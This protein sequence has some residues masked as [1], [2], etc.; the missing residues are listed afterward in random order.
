[1]ARISILIPD[2]ESTLTG[3][4]VHSLSADRSIDIHVL[5][6]DPDSAIQFSRFVKTFAVYDPKEVGELQPGPE[7]QGDT[8]TEELIRYHYYDA[9][10]SQHLIEAIRRRAK[11]V[12]ATLLFPVDEHIV[13][14]LSGHRD[15][16]RAFI[17]LA[18][19]PDQ[20]MFLTGIDKWKLAQFLKAHQVPHPTTV[21]YTAGMSN[22]ALQ[23]IRFPVII[24]PINLGNAQGIRS[25]E[26]ATELWEYLQHQKLTHE[27]IIQPLITGYDIDCSV[28]CRDGKIVA[29]TI[30][31]AIIHPKKKYRAAV[32]IEFLKNDRVLAVVDSMMK[33]LNWSGVAHIDLRYDQDD[34]QVKVIEINGRY[35]G[36][37]LGST[38]A[39]VNFPLLAVDVATGRSFGMPEFKMARYFMGKAPIPN[40]AKSLLTSRPV[41]LRETSLF[42]TLRDPMPVVREVLRKFRRRLS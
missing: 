35:W 8:E 4:V 20:E 2:G 6:K 38:G 27:Y 22:E 32:G 12:N 9:S 16:I 21:K 28:L 5:S 17:Q 29:Y 7:V 1:M 40:M 15:E 33:H 41:R 39:G 34:D 14:V 3:H 37:L 25:F 18:P 10:R 36:S 31:K 13:K 42:Y 26:T 11:E 19:L 30:Q 23:E 24:K